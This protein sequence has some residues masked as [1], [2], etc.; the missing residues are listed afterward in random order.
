MQSINSSA[1]TLGPQTSKT[2]KSVYPRTVIMSDDSMAPTF[3]E[4]DVLT[5]DGDISE[6]EGDYVLV[7]S[8]GELFD[9]EV[10]RR[11]TTVG[12]RENYV[13]ENPAY[14]E[15]LETDDF[16]PECLGPVTSVQRVDGTIETFDLSTRRKWANTAPVE[17][18]C[19]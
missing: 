8:H 5:I 17:A 4:G 7:H 13:P 6:K 2:P 12:D 15:M 10:I 9:L 11:Y 3:V 14:P 1:L 16:P 19:A 18:V